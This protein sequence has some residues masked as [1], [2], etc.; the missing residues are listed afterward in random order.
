LIGFKHPGN[1]GMLKIDYCN[2]AFPK[3]T[4][5]APHQ[6]MTW[7][8]FPTSTPVG[9]LKKFSPAF[10]TGP[11]SNKFGLPVPGLAVKVSEVESQTVTVPVDNFVRNS[12]LNAKKV[13]P[14]VSGPIEALPA[15]P[16][17]F[18]STKVPVRCTVN[19][20]LGNEE[21]MMTGF[22]SSPQAAKM[23]TNKNRI[24]FFIIDVIL[25][26]PKLPKAYHEKVT[27]S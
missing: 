14:W 6:S 12:L 9:I 21:S 26:A 23:I 17:A 16:E 10:L 2:L 7:V 20:P 8:Y 15:L 5:T 24:T 3:G 13:V 25:F 4:L 27:K 19:T 22:S 18:W 1:S 11:T